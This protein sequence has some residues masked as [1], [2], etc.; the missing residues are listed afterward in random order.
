MAEHR[1]TRPA[2]NMQYAGPQWE[3]LTV[4]KG[5]E[6]NHYISEFTSSEKHVDDLGFEGWEL[7][8]VDDTSLYYKR[9][10]INNT[11]IIVQSM[12]EADQREMP[13][14]V[15]VVCCAGVWL[16]LM[17]FSLGWLGAFN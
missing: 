13:T 2:R 3:Q 16:L 12:P 10:I 1:M 7:V 11:P 6:R 9:R 17:V 5:T 4:P 15:L 14:S 8:S